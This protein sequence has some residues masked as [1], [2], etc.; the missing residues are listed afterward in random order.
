MRI[1]DMESI[2]ES[3]SKSTPQVD[4]PRILS[5]M[6]DV[7]VHM[8]K[9]G[10]DS[11]RSKVHNEDEKKSVSLVSEVIDKKK[12]KDDRVWVSHWHGGGERS[13]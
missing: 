7:V 3:D 12:D 6:A 1:G 13:R 9:V 8:F 2:E 10:D 11:G 4:D 5:R